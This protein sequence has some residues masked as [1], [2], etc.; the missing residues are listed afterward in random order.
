MRLTVQKKIAIKL[1]LP[2]E[3][4]DTAKTTNNPKSFFNVNIFLTSYN[5]NTEHLNSIKNKKIWINLLI[6][7]IYQYTLFG[8]KLTDQLVLFGKLKN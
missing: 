8:I 6:Y 2:L 5:L 7:P 3:T 1:N 4:H